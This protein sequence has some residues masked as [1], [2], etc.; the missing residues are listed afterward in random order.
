[1]TPESTGQPQ[2]TPP[3]KS[4]KPAKKI[5]EAKEMVAA[6]L[7]KQASEAVERIV[8]DANE[9]IYYMTCPRQPNHIGII[10]NGVNPM[11]HD[12]F[13]GPMWYAFHHGVHEGHQDVFWGQIPGDIICQDCYANGG[14]EKVQLRVYEIPSSGPE[15]KVF[16]IQPR[17]K[18]EYIRSMKR[19]ELE[20]LMKEAQAHG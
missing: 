16:G 8:R 6:H 18:K 13:S 3:G 7:K 11:N 15:G 17:H 4:A 12:R 1:M 9:N 10:F 19:S 20:E 2:D 14:G 5:I